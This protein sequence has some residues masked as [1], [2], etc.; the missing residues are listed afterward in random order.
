[1]D[2]AYQVI[3]GAGSAVGVFGI[4]AALLAR[5]AR[6]P[7]P[8]TAPALA[9]C[10]QDAAAGEPLPPPRPLTLRDRIE[11]FLNAID[12]LR[13]R[14]EWRY[15]TPWMLLLGERG[16][17]KTSAL[18]SVS[19]K[20]RLGDDA[21][22][23][24]RKALAVAGTDWQ[25]LKQGA[26]IDPRGRMPAAAPGSPDAMA[27]A[28]VLDDIDALRP[29]R[30]LDGIVLAVSARTLHN[31]TSEQRRILA[32]NALRQ[33]DTVAERFEFMLPVYVI[34]T[35]SDAIDGFTAFWRAQPDARKSEMFGWSAP[36]AAVNGTPQEWADSAF[37]VLGERLKSLQVEAAA[38]RDSIADADRFFLFPRHFMQLRLPLKEWLGVVF[39]SSAWRAGFLCRGIYFTGSIAADGADSKEV[40]EDIAFIDDLVT[41]KVLAEPHL[42]KPT[43]RGVWSRNML[44]RAVQIAGV[45]AFCGLL[46][47]LAIAAVQLNRQVDALISSLRLVQDIRTVPES[48]ENCIAKDRVYDLLAHVSRI[49]AS[50]MYLAIPVSWIDAHATRKS[51][52]MI[53]EAALQRVVMPGLACQ[54]ELRARELSAHTPTIAGGSGA[55]AYQQSRRALF[56]TL[57]SVQALEDNL[58]RFRKL[59][60][61]A[62]SSEQ[63]RMLATLIDLTEYA[64][65]SAVPDA[66]KHERGALAAAL[67]AMKYDGNVQLPVGMQQRLTEQITQLSS[68][69]QTQFKREVHAGS[70]LLTQLSNLQEPILDNTRHFTW[71]L[72]WVRKSWLGS[73]TRVNPCQDIR[74]ELMAGVDQLVA[75]YKYPT[76]L[77]QLGKQ[78]DADTCYKPAMDTLADMQLAPN[79]LLFVRKNGVLQLNPDLLPESN[80]LTALVALNYMQIDKVRDFSCRGAMAGWRATDIAQASGYAREYQNFA[81]AQGLPA[82]SADAGKQPLYDK[83][84]RRQLELVM[85]NSLRDAQMPVAADAADAAQKTGL[86][87]ASQADQQLAQQSGAF[88][89]SVD[90]LIGVLRTYEQYGFRSRTDISECARNFASDS[91]AGVSTLVA[92]SRVYDPEQSAGSSFFNLGS[93]AVTKD[94]LARQVARSQVL[95]GYATP[96]VNFLQNTK[97][98]NDAQKTN[99]Q[100]APYWNNTIAELNRYVQFKEPN[101]QVAQLDTLFLKQLT[102]LTSANC[103]K[104]LDYQPA[105]YGND[106]FSNRR[107]QLDEQI[108]WRCDDGR[109]AQAF[110]AY[111][112]I[113]QRFA[114][115]LADRYPFAEPGK[116]DASLA[117]VKAFFAYYET[118][119]SAA[120]QVVAALSGSQKA[121]VQAF[122]DQLDTASLFFNGTLTGTDPSQPVKLTVTFNLRTGDARGADQIV[123][124]SL[125]SGTKSIGFPNRPASFD[126]QYGQPLVLDLAWANRSLVRPV[127]DTKQADQSIEGAS[128][129]FS[130]G[131]DWALLRMI[132]A[133]RPKTGAA[134]DALDP[135]RT[136]LEFNVPT[137]PDKS[138]PGATP[139]DTARLYVGFN[140]AAKDP[141][142]QA[143]VA[144]ELPNGFPRYAPKYEDLTWTRKSRN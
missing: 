77:E 98:V 102:D 47:A 40:R 61:P 143:P 32:E 141:K 19:A 11:R 51:A 142:T 117:A 71:W 121:S 9:G 103:S 27:W 17:G 68:G 41:K 22:D 75:R 69:L 135:S 42:A 125:T 119:A 2:L 30:A 21:S 108:R 111:R 116:R 49:D 124:W 36:A 110:T 79:S 20:H 105:E 4:A 91:L 134:T 138:P 64:Y 99:D 82:T 88:A 113:S 6:K 57:Q 43:R 84:A 3:A 66:V 126:W 127:R 118:Q 60:A 33:I 12:Y 94:Y 85:S 120:R 83:L 90:Q 109:N 97:A 139:V 70:A 95:A 59:A 131:G 13:T 122:L 114:R 133:H 39:Q 73:T 130:A 55:D 129:S 58:A 89:G 44:I 56:D 115:D 24:Q 52:H 54:L 28:G 25:F 76:R 112:E 63:S 87:A 50:S 128:A 65:G 34:V 144:L 35:E 92:N 107:K 46:V 123:N 136:L 72:T 53:A 38:E 45:T 137:V 15:R 5:R 67:T 31:A 100:T 101:G 14:R 104:T 132:E 23:W 106:L 81:K 37:D 29:E 74:G 26:V 1:V 48:G 140:F 7:A 8:V 78:F 93:T 96:F 18:A 10:C 16:A 80:G 62:S 86:D